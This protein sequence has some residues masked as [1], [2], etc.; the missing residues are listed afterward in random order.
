MVAPPTQQ[1]SRDAGDTGDEKS[2]RR[3]RRISRDE[4]R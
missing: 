3:K 4:H 1:I 2:G